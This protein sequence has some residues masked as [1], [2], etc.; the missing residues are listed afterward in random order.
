M[1]KFAIS[2]LDALNWA[3][4]SKAV[5]DLGGKVALGTGTDLDLDSSKAE[6][7]SNSSRS[8]MPAGSSDMVG[9]K[10]PIKAAIFSIFES[11]FLVFCLH[12]RKI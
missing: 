6:A 12:S 10:R 3:D 8:S 2:A 5:L 9:S 1:A 11:F 7:E 4:K